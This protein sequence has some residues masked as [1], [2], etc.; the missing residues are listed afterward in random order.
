MELT[1]YE[2]KSIQCQFDCFCKKIMRNEKI[3]VNCSTFDEFYDI[4]KEELAKD[5]ERIMYYNN[6][7]NDI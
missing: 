2:K 4:Y 7:F 3:E 6:K 1:P 5:L